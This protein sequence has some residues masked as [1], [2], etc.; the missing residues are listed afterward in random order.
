[1]CLI[2]ALMVPFGHTVSDG[3]DKYGQPR[4]EPAQVT[5]KSLKQP[6]YPEWWGEAP[7]IPKVVPCKDPG[8]CV[9]CHENQASMD[10]SHAISCV[11]CHGGDPTSDNKDVAHTG[12]RVGIIR[13]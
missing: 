7:N 4:V 12:L 1:M 11:R 13:S 10:P 3:S 8:A 5:S 6:L 9:A 2:V